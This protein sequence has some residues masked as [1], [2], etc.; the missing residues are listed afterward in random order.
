M[1]VTHLLTVP[2]ATAMPHVSLNTPAT[3]EDET[4]FAAQLV[5]WGPRRE[6]ATRA[7]DAGGRPEL[8]VPLPDDLGGARWL[9][10]FV[11]SHKPGA[12]GL[13]Q[14]AAI[15]PDAAS[16]RLP[17]SMQEP[18]SQTIITHPVPD[19]TELDVTSGE[20]EIPAGAELSFHTGIN[21]SWLGNQVPALAFIVTAVEDGRETEVHRAVLD[22]AQRP[23]D[24]KWVAQRADLSALAGLTV[25]F[26]FAARLADGRPGASL[27]LWGN[28]TMRAPA[29]ESAG[30]AV[31]LPPNVVLIS[32]DTLRGAST[33]IGGARRPTT[34]CVD[35]LAAEGVT[36]DDAITTAPHTLPAHASLFSGLYL[37][38]HGV[39]SWATV[40]DPAQT[41]FTERLFDAGYA[42]AAFTEDG[43]VLPSVGIG[44]G[45]EVY[46][47]D[48][49][50]DIHLPVGY[51]AQTFRAGLDWIER[52][53]ADDIRAGGGARQPFFL[54]LHTYQ[55][56]APYV[57]PPPYDTAFEP[58]DTLPGSNARDLLRYE[59]EVRYLD[60][61]LCAFVHGLD[62]LGLGDHTL[63]VV[64]SDHGEEFGE[65]GQTGHGFQVYDET[66]RIVLVLRLPGT[67][68]AG[69]HI[70][71]PVSLVDVAPTM[72]ALLGLPGL[73]RP[74][75]VSLL[76]M[77][78]GRS[79]PLP[80]TG[81]FTETV[82]SLEEPE[83]DVIG[84]RTAMESCI[85]VTSKDHAECFDRTIDRAETGTGH[86]DS[87]DPRF[88]AAR[89]AVTEFQ[90]TSTTST[91]PS[92]TAPAVDSEREKKLRA[93]G[94]I[95]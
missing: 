56:H 64:I 73:P 9:A 29:T 85:F 34:P 90:R 80:R 53:R 45:F 70:P 62:G 77:A 48:K 43:F 94:Y 95:Q 36:F 86:I 31:P 10:V 76:P 65:H 23:E 82:S 83:I 27:P 42:T 11:P 24:R 74:D 47:E 7:V 49:S 17:Y 35:A 37:R 88:V 66:A 2:G 3:I 13:V 58:S 4:H 46:R 50:P 84:Y 20:I 26:R 55:V 8:V 32:L 54:F 75:G 78:L 1:A 81:V 38:H 41:T 25:R 59:Q 28:P 89:Q 60:D 93:L 63:L 18:D 72:L 16:V 87:F 91:I 19:V 71:V 14:I 12:G 51:A 44:R 22:P 69:R 61:Q 5:P 6:T 79:D 68:P 33:G 21:T 39:R 30:P 40:L 57:P 92:E 52:H 67:L 15:A